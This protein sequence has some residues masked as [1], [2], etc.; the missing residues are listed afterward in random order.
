MLQVP[1]DSLGV[2]F[3]EEFSQGWEEESGAGARVQKFH[4]GLAYC[5]QRSCSSAEGWA[6]TDLETVQGVEGWGQV[7]PICET[8]W[9][10]RDAGRSMGMSGDRANAPGPGRRPAR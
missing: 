8:R 2:A 5:R 3:R 7:L 10:A 6:E 1:W 9:D 4:I